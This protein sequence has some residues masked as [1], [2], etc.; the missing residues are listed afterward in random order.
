M[1]QLEKRDPAFVVLPRYRVP[2]VEVAAALSGRWDKR[3]LI[4]V[5][6]ITNSTNE[7][8]VIAGPRR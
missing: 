1:S 4:G 8:T 5:R 3:W 7:R 6:D 2:E